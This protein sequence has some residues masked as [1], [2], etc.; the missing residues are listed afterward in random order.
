MRES[1]QRGEA[2]GLS[3]L[4][5]KRLP[6][7]DTFKEQQLSPTSGVLNMRKYRLVEH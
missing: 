7:S 1:L 4:A 2:P 3:E 5:F 6:I